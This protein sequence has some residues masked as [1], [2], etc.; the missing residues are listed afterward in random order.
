MEIPGQSDDIS[1]LDIFRLP[2]GLPEVALKRCNDLT[3][4]DDDHFWRQVNFNQFILSRLH[5][6]IC[7][8]KYPESFVIIKLFRNN[9]ENLV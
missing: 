3:H 9:Q 2:V 7:L 1:E 8:I 6:R 5:T 4:N